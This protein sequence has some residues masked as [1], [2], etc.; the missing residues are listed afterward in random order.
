M[1]SLRKQ[2]VTVT[3]GA[4]NMYNT[5]RF[6]LL[7][8][9]FVFLFSFSLIIISSFQI[10]AASYESDGFVYSV[11]YGNASI[12]GYK[13]DKSDVV[14]PLKFE[15]WS[16]TEISDFAFSSKSSITSLNLNEAR[17]LSRIGTNA[18]YGCSSVESVSIPVWVKEFGS[19]VFQNCSNLK[20]VTFNNVPSEITNQMFLNC[21]SLDNVYLPSGTK[22]IGRNSFAGCTSLSNIFIPFSVTSIASNAFRSSPN[23]TITGYFGSY[24]EEYAK[25]NNIPF[26]AISAYAKG[27]VN[28][29][30]NVGITDATLIQKI[31]VNLVEPTAE[32]SYLADYND[33]GDIS[34][35]DATDIQKRIVHLD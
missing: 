3:I 18:F 28:M 15:N 17:Y 2:R 16:V 1:V 29:D 5:Q 22:S 9:I 23:V 33:D 19:A 25:A 27:D 35:V 7:K 12:T 10:S 26:N 8:K 32:Q 24:A 34:V 21:S 14:I 11:A 31:A 13:S 4:D 30:G 20:S 6:T